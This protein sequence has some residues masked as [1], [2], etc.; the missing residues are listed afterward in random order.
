KTMRILKKKAEIDAFLRLLRKRAAGADPGVGKTV[1]AIL[2]DVKKKGDIAVER[3]TRKFDKHELPLRLKTSEIK[4][5][6]A[7]ADKNIIKALEISASRI[8]DFH[9]VQKEESWSYEVN[10]AVLG[11]IIR[12]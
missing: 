2:A 10:G 5:H 12:P 7:K 6:A 9:E 1:R 11:Q 3:Y 8:R 4:K